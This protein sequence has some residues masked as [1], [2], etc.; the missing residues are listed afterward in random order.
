M[1]NNTTVSELD[2]EPSFSWVDELDEEKLK[3]DAYCFE[4]FRSA[5]TMRSKKFTEALIER[6]ANVNAKKDGE[7][8]KGWTPLHCAVSIFCSC[9]DE[10]RSS[11]CVD[12]P[13]LNKDI[14]S[15]L[16]ENGADVNV[17]TSGGMTQLKLSMMKLNNSG[18]TE[19]LVEAGANIDDIDNWTLLPWAA[20][21]GRKEIIE[22][23][24]DKGADINAEYYS[25]L[26]WTM[27]HCAVKFG[28]KEIVEFLIDKGAD[29]NKRTEFNRSGVNI[30]PLH[31]IGAG[32]YKAIGELL[33]SN[34]AEIDTKDFKNE[35]PL[36]Y[37]V[38]S[39]HDK[40]VIEFLIEKGADV[41]IK[42][43][44][45]VK[46]TVLHIAAKR[47]N[48]DAIK[49]LI[50]NGAEVDSKD[51]YDRTPLYYAID[52]SSD[53]DVIKF[54]IDK[55][56]D[57]N[58]K[59]FNN[60]MPLH[61]AAQRN[62]VEA[63]KLLISK[64]ADINAKNNY[65]DTPL[66]VT[67]RDNGE[68]ITLLEKAALEQAK[69]STVLTMEQMPTIESFLKEVTNSNR[70]NG[71]IDIRNSEIPNATPMMLP[72]LDQNLGSTAN[73]TSLLLRSDANGTPNNE[74]SS[75]NGNVSLMF[76]GYLCACVCRKMFSPSTIIDT[77]SLD[78]G[79]L[80]KNKY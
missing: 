49:L 51:D 37:A 50:N 62:N 64:G 55:G 3:D 20:A 47:N 79:N 30:T 39:N 31:L 14:V 75:I 46:Y 27:L 78:Q 18:I 8:L 63:V 41:N 80:S 28:Q 42:S 71:I 23:R 60:N 11:D 33:I 5:F 67:S 57:V 22:S 26:D 54:L 21:N 19:L 15:L 70:S 12:N 4:L 44:N 7:G 38:D 1:V 29:V 10:Q 56:A 53:I 65:F 72:H 35:T 69:N 52:Y 45:D 16:I 13:P 36:F 25:N 40:G 73:S 58:V 61:I 76:I 43:T 59:I 74:I 9:G 24:L 2:L 77:P 34:G 48:V 6:G 68:I 17:K 32:D 66:E